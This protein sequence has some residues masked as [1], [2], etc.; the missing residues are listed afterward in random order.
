LLRA[1]AIRK[2]SSA[3]AVACR[4]P[5]RLGGE[6]ALPQRFLAGLGRAG[7]GHRFARCGDLG[8]RQV[9]VAGGGDLAGL[10]GGDRRIGLGQ[11]Q[12]I[13]FGID[14]EQQ[15]AGPDLLV[16]LDQDRDDLSAHFGADRDLV[17]LDIGVVG[18]DLALQRKP[19]ANG[20]DQDQ[21]RNR[22]H[23]R[24]APPTALGFGQLRFHR[25]LGIGL[26]H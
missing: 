12:P 8:A 9:A 1:W 20:A 11:F 24:E 19:V 26:S 13:G 21:Q 22:E 18:S 7:K 4:F 14:P 3:W 2:V 6:T 10:G 16:L 17:E 5:V 23:Q 15:V 25:D